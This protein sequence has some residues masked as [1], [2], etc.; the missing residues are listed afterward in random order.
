MSIFTASWEQ[1]QRS[2]GNVSKEK[3]EILE[4]VYAVSCNFEHSEERRN[5]KMR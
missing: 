5:K 1:Y 3:E 4:V 2:F